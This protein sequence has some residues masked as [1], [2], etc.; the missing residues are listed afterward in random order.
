MNSRFQRETDMNTDLFCLT[1]SAG[2]CAA[3]WVPYVLSWIQTWLGRCSRLPGKSTCC[4]NLGEA[5]FEEIYHAFKPGV[6]L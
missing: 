3:L 2:L 4:V 5:V 6:R 1:L